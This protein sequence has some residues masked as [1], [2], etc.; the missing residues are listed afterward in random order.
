MS[1]LPNGVMNVEF[2]THKNTA[3]EVFDQKTYDYYQPP[4]KRSNYNPVEIKPKSD[5]S[6]DNLTLLGNIYN[7]QLEI[8]TN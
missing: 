2:L 6:D 1:T 8:D 7:N 4:E 3:S 5:S